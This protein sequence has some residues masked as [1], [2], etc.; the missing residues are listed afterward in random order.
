[1]AAEDGMKT[2]SVSVCLV[3]LVAVSAAC[4]KDTSS[5]S[6]P[7]ASASTQAAS[8]K[9][10]QASAGGGDGK[11]CV[12]GAYKDPSGTYC[13]KLPKGVT[14]PKKT[15]KSDHD[16]EDEFE[17]SEDGSHTFT[18]KY[19]TPIPSYAFTF[20]DIKKQDMQETDILKKV[21]NEDIANGNGFYSVRRESGSLPRLYSNSVV[22]KGAMLITCEA[23][24]SERNPMTPPDACK[25]LRAM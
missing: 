13:V 8:S 16:S 5:T 15:E 14:P 7:A 4:K 18:I 12:E 2:I 3:A 11:N 21:S 20:E 10:E 24:Y 23:S 17:T 6:G 9:P 1:M 22:K 25:T 19:W